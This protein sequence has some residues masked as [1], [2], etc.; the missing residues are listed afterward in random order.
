[1]MKN[2]T[3]ITC[4]ADLDRE[5]IRVRKRIKK[6]E[7]AIKEKLQTLPEEIVTAGITK[8][9]TSILNGDLF[10]SAV[11]IIKTIGTV[12]SGSKKESSGTNGGIINL[13]KSIVKDKLSS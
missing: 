7:V 2:N 10:K 12:L 5:E 3:I 9:V 11:S 13:I 1:M 4:F 6:Q 8:I